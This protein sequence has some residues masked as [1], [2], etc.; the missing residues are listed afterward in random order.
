MTEVQAGWT[1]IVA[2]LLGL[3]GSLVFI[4]AFVSA[5]VWWK[6]RHEG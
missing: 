3:G 2:G 6:R 4:G 5:L 1:E